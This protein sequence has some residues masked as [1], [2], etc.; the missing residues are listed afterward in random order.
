LEPKQPEWIA[1]QQR[2][3]NLLGTFQASIA[4]F[5]IFALL[6]AYKRSRPD[7]WFYALLAGVFLSG[8][9]FH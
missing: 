9:L 8:V 3:W 6:A 4:L 1:I 7:A 2:F 5:A